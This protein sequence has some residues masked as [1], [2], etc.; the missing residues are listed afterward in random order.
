MEYKEACDL[1]ATTFPTTTREVQVAPKRKRP[2]GAGASIVQ[3]GESS[4]LQGRQYALRRE[5]QVSEALAGQAEER[6]GDRRA[7]ERIADLA[8]AGRPRIDVDELDLHLVRQVG[9]AHHIVV[10]EVGLFH[11]SILDGH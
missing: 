5:R 1:T 6:V 3:A 8:K 9:H 2:P 7:D 10:V 11:G 4:S